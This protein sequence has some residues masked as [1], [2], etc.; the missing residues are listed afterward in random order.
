MNY[1]VH[2]YL[3]DEIS[4]VVGIFLFFPSSLSFF[5]LV[6]YTNAWDQDT[7]NDNSPWR[8]L[9]PGQKRDVNAT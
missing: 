5:P 1:T 6:T 2:S 7:G 8:D 4:Q 3:P 9:G